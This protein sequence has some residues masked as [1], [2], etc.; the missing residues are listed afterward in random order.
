MG[1][2]LLVPD[3]K[4]FTHTTG[5]IGKNLG[6]LDEIV[7]LATI[8]DAV[9][10]LLIDKLPNV[11]AMEGY[12]FGRAFNACTMGEVGCIVKLACHDAGVPLKIIAPTT[13][14]KFVTGHGKSDKAVMRTKIFS[15]WKREFVTQDEAEA[16]AVAQWAAR[17]S[18]ERD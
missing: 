13:L 9:R 10:N 3:G 8:R 2:C 4:R 5:I 17:Y 1:W 14:K 18:E 15:K 16:F 7:R 12:A 6:G 11:A